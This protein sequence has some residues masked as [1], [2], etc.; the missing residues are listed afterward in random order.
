MKITNKKARFNYEIIETFEAGI[1]LFGFEVKSLKTKTGV[2]DGSYV[3]VRDGEAYLINLTIPPY[4]ESN[5]PDWYNPKRERK[6][7]L[8]KE[9]I[10]KIETRR[11][12]AGLTVTP[13]SLYNK[14]GLIKVQI[15]LARGKKKFDKREAIKRRDQERD[16]GRTLKKR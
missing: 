16:L 4:Q 2:L 8:K 1:Q 7:L 9:E 11:H 15:G 14:N 6:L 10:K 5:T 3:T 12:E 13:L